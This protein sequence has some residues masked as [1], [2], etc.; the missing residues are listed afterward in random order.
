M[1]LRITRWIAY[2]YIHTYIAHAWQ[3]ENSFAGVFRVCMH[4]FVSVCLHACVRLFIMEITHYIT[5]AF[6]S[7]GQLTVFS[8]YMDA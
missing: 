3:S 1:S 5:L 4:A 8:R 6:F 7:H 2:T